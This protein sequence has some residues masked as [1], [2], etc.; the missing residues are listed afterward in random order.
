M[1]QDNP[2]AELWALDQMLYQETAPK[3]RPNEL[4]KDSAKQPQQ[5]PEHAS[6]LA[7]Q[8]ASK[9]TKKQTSKPTSEQTNK[10]TNQQTSKPAKPHLTTKEKRKYGTYLRED[11]ILAIQVHSIQ[12]KRRDR[13]VLQEA[14]DL[15]FKS[16]KK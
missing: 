12:T 13:E 14:V 11:S 4:G 8:Q 5:T 10:E 9:P 6:L 16:I 2:F 15:Y 7:N 3:T 1:N